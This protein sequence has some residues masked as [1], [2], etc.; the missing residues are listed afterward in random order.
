ELG[1]IAWQAGNVAELEE[2]IKRLQELA[3]DSRWLIFFKGVHSMI[4]GRPIIARE[5]LGALP[6]DPMVDKIIA[7]AWISE[8]GFEPAALILDSLAKD[9][10]VCFLKGCIHFE[11]RQ[12]EEALDQLLQ[13]T[14]FRFVQP[15]A[16]Y[17]LSRT[18]HH[19]G[20]LDESQKAIEV[21]LKYRPGRAD[22]LEWK[23]SITP[24]KTKDP[25]KLPHI[26]VVTGLPRSGTSLMM[27]ILDN[28]GIPV[29]SDGQRKA[30][31]FNPDGYFELESIKEM[32][33]TSKMIEGAEGKALKIVI[34]LIRF[35]PP[36]AHYKVIFMNREIS[37][38]I[39][40]QDRLKGEPRM[41]FPLDLAMQ[42]ENERERTRKWLDDQPHIQ[43]IEVS[44]ER[45]KN[46]E[47][48]Q[49]QDIQ[50]FLGIKHST[51]WMSII[52][53]E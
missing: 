25:E 18:F 52:R 13:S 47:E 43:W 41:E 16:H 40:S 29:L 45:L 32:P 28:S 36:K 50:D 7:R 49:I 39:R 12:W 10:E 31:P 34:P 6:R 4:L 51:K 3:P 11:R 42:L 15:D 53:S 2:T 19:L 1:M 26:W 30:D 8:G 35:I 23:R 22:M 17:L 27:Q 9:D 37:D 14:G 24:E 48:K 21:A 44:Y 33:Y 5:Y 38:V 20:M 46:R